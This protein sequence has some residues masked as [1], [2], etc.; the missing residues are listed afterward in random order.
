[1]CKCNWKYQ[2]DGSLSIFYGFWDGLISL[3]C[4]AMFDVSVAMIDGENVRKALCGFYNIF[5]LKSD[6]AS[7]LKKTD[8]IHT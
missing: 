5:F 8:S 3:K 1:M 7:L 4:F 2:D 6:M